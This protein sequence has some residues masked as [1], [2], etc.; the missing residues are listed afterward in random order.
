MYK[1]YTIKAYKFKEISSGKGLIS[2]YLVDE[3]GEERVVTA[4]AKRGLIR[5][6]KSVEAIHY[7]ETPLVHALSKSEVNDTIVIDFSD[8]NRKHPRVNTGS[9]FR[10]TAKHSMV[11]IGTA[12]AMSG[13]HN[14]YIDKFR[15][16]QLFIISCLC[17]MVLLAISNLLSVY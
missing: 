11:E 1:T 13:V 7:R 14:L 8:F 5:K 4:K 2:Y 12:H 6:I 16:F 3:L 15:L 17:I 9:Q 10:K